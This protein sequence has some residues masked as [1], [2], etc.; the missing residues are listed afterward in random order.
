MKWPPKATLLSFLPSIHNGH[1]LSSH[2]FRSSLDQ[3]WWCFSWIGLFPRGSRRRKRMPVNRQ[4]LAINTD[5]DVGEEEWD[6]T[7][8][9]PWAHISMVVAHFPLP[10]ALISPAIEQ[11][12]THHWIYRGYVYIITVTSCS[13]KTQPIRYFPVVAKGQE[14][15]KSKSE[16]QNWFRL[17]LKREKCVT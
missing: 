14:K 4:K 2:H 9:K 13:A 15:K 12:A 10:W 1:T 11:P 17:I 5:R 3:E 8:S 16:I 6:R 7:E